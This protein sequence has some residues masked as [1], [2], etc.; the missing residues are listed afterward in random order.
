MM[1][2]TDLPSLSSLNLEM[3]SGETETLVKAQV[4]AGRDA[5]GDSSIFWYIVH[6]M[7]WAGMREAY[8][9]LLCETVSTCSWVA[10]GGGTGRTSLP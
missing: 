8:P 1:Y 7:G 10:S 4:L 9:D 3:H 2:L 5:T 6:D